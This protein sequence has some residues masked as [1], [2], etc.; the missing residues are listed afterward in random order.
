MCSQLDVRLRRPLTIDHRSL[1]SNVERLRK[2][3]I[4]VHDQFIV[5]NLFFTQNY[6]VRRP[7]I[8]DYTQYDLRKSYVLLL[9]KIIKSK[10]IRQYSKI[11][12]L[13]WLPIRG[14]TD[15]VTEYYYK[16]FIKRQLVE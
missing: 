3:Q 1:Q 7:I 9:D 16:H 12:N 6:A 4:H 8:A 10:L 13:L 2:Q 15:T 14:F 5:K 11:S